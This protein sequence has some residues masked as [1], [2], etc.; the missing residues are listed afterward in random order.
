MGRKIRDKAGGHRPLHPHDV[1][2]RSLM[3]WRNLAPR[4]TAGGNHSLRGGEAGRCFAAF[5][6]LSPEDVMGVQGV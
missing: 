1:F 4:L 3:Q 5:T 2:R 6:V